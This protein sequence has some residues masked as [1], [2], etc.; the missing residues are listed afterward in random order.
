M[1][2]ATLALLD[3]RFGDAETL[4]DEAART[5]PAG[6]GIEENG[7]QRVH[8]WLELGDGDRALG[9]ARALVDGAAANPIHDAMLAVAQARHAREQGRRGGVHVHPDR[10]DAV[11]HD[12]VERARELVLGQIVLILAHPD[13]LR[14]DLH[15]LRQRV[16]QAPCNRHGTP[17]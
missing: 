17:Q 4:A 5:A 10:V 2:R 7:R 13:R 3:G 11:F 16:L 12:R 8:L 14:V 1:F 6:M 9:E 15:Q